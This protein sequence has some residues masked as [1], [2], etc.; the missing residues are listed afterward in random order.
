M[1]RVHT[2][3]S[4]FSETETAHWRDET[5]NMVWCNSLDSRDGGEGESGQRGESGGGGRERVEIWG[6]SVERHGGEGGA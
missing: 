3:Q 2:A 6:E 5:N 4:H 1:R